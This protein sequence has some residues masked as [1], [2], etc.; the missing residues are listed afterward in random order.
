MANDFPADSDA[1]IIAQASIIE[2]GVKALISRS[3]FNNGY[4]H[5]EILVSEKGAYAIDANFGRIG[6]GALIEQFAHSYGTTVSK[7]A[8]HV[9]D[10][11][12]FNGRR[13]SINPFLKKPVPSLSLMYGIEAEGVV[14]GVTLPQVL[15]SLHTFTTKFGTFVPAMGNTDYCWIGTLAGYPETVLKEIKEI[16]VKTK[17]GIVPAFYY[18]HK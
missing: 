10:V 13:S 7:V 11:G 9:L 17:A 1:R 14:E 2:A 6:G 5:Y 8:A 3:G 4:F 12:L 18:V 15:S 16:Q